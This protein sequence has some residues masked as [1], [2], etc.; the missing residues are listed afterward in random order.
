MF[1][2][3]KK[4]KVII[5]DCDGVL[6]DWGHMFHRWMYN[7]GYRIQEEDTYNMGKQYGIGDLDGINLIKQFN[8][9]AAIGYLPPYK[10]AV[11]YVKKLHE[12]H[13]FMFHVI[14][15]LTSDP[16]GKS[17][18]KAN[19][20]RI[21]GENVFEYIN[22]LSLGEDKGPTLQENYQNTGC[23]FVDDLPSNVYGAN[24]AGL[25]GVLMSHS[26]NEDCTDLDR[27]SNWKTLYEFIC[28]FS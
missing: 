23:W 21:F 18:R 12:E 16:W 11:H 7:N 24:D 8:A 14:T 5:V 3:V 10:D 26:H 28:R 13:G 27:V 1:E 22:V 9:S 25:T 19:L 6:L 17:A 20:R 4:D 15:S 2:Y